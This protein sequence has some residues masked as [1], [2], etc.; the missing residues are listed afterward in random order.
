[1]S[2]VKWRRI[3]LDSL[4][5]NNY[6]GSIGDTKYFAQAIIPEEIIYE[7]VYKER[8][9]NNLVLDIS[10]WIFTICILSL[11]MWI[12][13]INDCPGN[14]L[15]NNNH[16]CDLKISPN[17][18]DYLSFGQSFLLG[19]VSLV[20]DIVLQIGYNLITAH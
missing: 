5:K 12:S 9:M 16:R 8:K 2:S 7:N 3:L 1:M 6:L 10:L 17:A 15:E 4:I 19:I 20:T 13:N 18:S 11:K 14:L